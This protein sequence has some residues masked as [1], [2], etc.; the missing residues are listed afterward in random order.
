L[1]IF[2]DM[3]AHVDVSFET[4]LKVFFIMLKRLVLNV[5]YVNMSINASITFDEVC[6]FMKN[7][8]ENAKYKRNVLSK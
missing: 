7:Y 1:I 3:C 6:L 8:L 2:N 5:Y 4:K